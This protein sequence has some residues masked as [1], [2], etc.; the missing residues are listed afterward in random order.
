MASQVAST[1]ELEGKKKTKKTEVT[2]MEVTKTEVS[3]TEAMETE[4]MA[5]TGAGVKAV[6]AAANLKPS[7]GG[8]ERTNSKEPSGKGD[9]RGDERGDSKD[10]AG[11]E[12]NGSET[13]EKGEGARS[14]TKSRKRRGAGNG[15]DEP[16][17]R[18]TRL[19]TKGGQ[20][21]DHKSRR[22]SHPAGSSRGAWPSITGS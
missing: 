13:E 17:A 2:K 20:R 5:K 21:R 11:E 15:A 6:G 22:K 1:Q 9:G 3:K 10:P 12:R 19:N 14:A 16:P 7:G 8:H 18:K 4:T